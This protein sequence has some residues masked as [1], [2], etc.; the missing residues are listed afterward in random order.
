MSEQTIT[1]TLG[2]LVCHL[3]APAFW[4]LH[5]PPFLF[6]G[7]VSVPRCV[8]SYERHNILKM[9]LQPNQVV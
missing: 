6:M 7:F 2:E 5:I 4:H 1:R 8:L 3:H 9:L